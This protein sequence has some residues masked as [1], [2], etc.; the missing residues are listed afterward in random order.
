M[1]RL[2]W[3]GARRTGGGTI[4]ELGVEIRCGFQPG[5]TQDRVQRHTGGGLEE[6]Q[7]ARVADQ[8]TMILGSVPLMRASE[9]RGLTGGDG[10]EQEQR[11][12]TLHLVVRPA[13][14]V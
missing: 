9:R 1:N 11:D 8:T 7:G 13:R 2:R 10:E 14:H 4:V 3:R 5:K 12:H 6:K